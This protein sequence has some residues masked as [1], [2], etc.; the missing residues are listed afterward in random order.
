M[1]EPTLL[2]YARYFELTRNYT[3]DEIL[4]GM[5][6]LQ[7]R[8]PY[9][10]RRE[11]SQE[12]NKRYLGLLDTFYKVAE[13][14]LCLYHDGPLHV[15]QDVTRFLDSC[16]AVPAVARSQMLQNMLPRR[17]GAQGPKL[18]LPLL[19]IGGGDVDKDARSIR[20]GVDLQRAIQHMVYDGENTRKTAKPSVDLFAATPAEI[21]E[22]AQ[23]QVKKVLRAAGVEVTLT[24]LQILQEAMTSIMSRPSTHEAHLLML[25]TKQLR[26]APTPYCIAEDELDLRLNDDMMCNS[27]EPTVCDPDDVSAHVKQE[28]D[29]LTHLDNALTKEISILSPETDNK[30][31]QSLMKKSTNHNFDDN[32]LDCH[33]DDLTARLSGR[34]EPLEPRSGHGFQQLVRPQSFG[35][36]ADA[37]LCD[38]VDVGTKQANPVSKNSFSEHQNQKIAMTNLVSVSCFLP[39]VN[40][41][42]LLGGL[43]CRLDVRAW[44][45]AHAPPIPDLLPFEVPDMQDVL[46]EPM[47]TTS[48][49]LDKIAAMAKKLPTSKDLLWKGERLRVFDKNERDIEDT[50]AEHYCI[51]G[52]EIDDTV[53]DVQLKA[54]QIGIK[55]SSRHGCRIKLRQE[56]Q[57]YANPFAQAKAECAISNKPLSPQNLPDAIKREN[58]LSA[59]MKTAPAPCPPLKESCKRPRHVAFTPMKRKGKPETE[60]TE[61]RIKSALPTA[62]KQASHPNMAKM[63]QLDSRPWDSATDTLFSF[64]DLRGRQFK[65]PAL[66]GSWRTTEI[67]GD[68]IQ[69]TQDTLEDA[70][71]SELNCA[72]VPERAKLDSEAIKIFA[73]ASLGSPRAIVVNNSLLQ[74]KPLLILYLERTEREL[75]RL[76]YRDLDMQGRRGPDIILNATSCLLITNAQALEQR[77]LP[78]QA[79]ETG[80]SAVHDD[81]V[82]LIQTYSQMIVLVHYIEAADS[83]L[84]PKLR[85]ALATFTAFCQNPS[86]ASSKTPAYVYPVWLPCRIAVST[87]ELVNAW[88]WR[89]IRQHGYGHRRGS[90]I[91]PAAETLRQDETLWEL[92]LREAGINPLAAQLILGLLKK[93]EGVRGAQYDQDL[94]SLRRFVAMS[95]CERRQVFEQILE[96]DTIDRLSS[97]LQK[98]G[99]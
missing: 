75:L 5:Q 85:S 46:K 29:L 69:S 3:E 67:P 98:Q 96:K 39:Q 81:M 83:L 7:S 78:G 11:A 23:E 26:A 9:S 76:I 17:K 38:N 8:A 94:W 50:T 21:L 70:P 95:A 80:L 52:E 6:Q 49:F 35:L 27:S 74:H 45:K 65:N 97:L 47:V 19:I 54:E 30:T 61:K 58:G 64:L 2:E 16:R 60:T 55:E 73:W 14:H 79:S 89:L 42:D 91:L 10:Q 59:A 57:L 53:K 28:P 56:E 33:V 25:P 40:I 18:S 43:H 34:D 93:A 99:I 48:P 22:M 87:T 44:N 86:Q 32:T 31:M 66:S 12:S 92:F 4:D 90:E 77:Q 51:D 37:F 84:N 71:K 62:Q 13:Q 68:P 63:H 20:R 1:S 72:D 15:S 24:S 36:P 88:V 82:R 41:G